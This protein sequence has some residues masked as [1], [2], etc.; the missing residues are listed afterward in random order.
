MKRYLLDTNIV[1]ELRKP[2]THGAVIQWLSGLAD[3]QV[4]LSAITLGEL[5]TGVERTRGQDPKKANEIE[6][7]VD[8]VAASFQ[9]LPMDARCFREYARLAEGKPDHHFEDI[10]IAATSRVHDL[11]VATRNQK[12]FEDLGVLII[13]PFKTSG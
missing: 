3:E 7:W 8:Q 6:E 4:F 1:S 10:M 5:Q 9:V 11:V 12:D 2:K 13:N